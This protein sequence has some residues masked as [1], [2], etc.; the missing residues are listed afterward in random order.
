MN[1]GITLQAYTRRITALLA[2]DPGIKGVWVIAE[3]S[4]V[5]RH[6]SGHCYMEL[7]QK[8][9]MTGQT[10]AKM[11]ATL[12]KWKCIELDRK[13]Y[14]GTGQRF[15]SGMKVLLRLE[16]NHTDLYGLTANI[17][18]IDPAYTMGEMERIRR[19]I[20]EKLA[21]KGII[22]KNKQ[23]RMSLNPQMIA[24]ISAAGAAGYGDFV[25]QINSSPEGYVFYPKLF[26]AVM[27]GTS[28]A[29]SVIEALRCIEATI[30][31][32]DCV[33]IIRGGGATTDLNGFDNYELAEEI[34]NYSLPVIV[35]IGHERDR[36]V[37]DDIAAVRCKTPTAVAAFLID[38]MRRAE[39]IADDI[40]TDILSVIRQKLAFQQ[41]RLARAKALI[42]EIPIKR[43]QAESRNLT[44][45]GEYIMS[46]AKGRTES[47]R[48]KL[49]LLP[50][51]LRS[52]IN[53]ALKTQDLKIDHYKELTNILSPSNTLQRGYSITR[54]NGKAIRSAAG[55][56]EGA[57]LVTTLFD[58]SLISKKI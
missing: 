42:P 29:T 46:T 8:D 57:E 43:I 27:Q 55:I 50:E 24:V 40:A 38:S 33:V 48:Q 13:F 4:D 18:D 51:M 21:K 30:D 34:A 6:P 26:P 9:E 28:T 41:E 15:N 39:K 31:L 49:N 23:Q 19:E 32:W 20:L 37:L 45:L 3:L 25:N 5:N 54:V 11:R 7:I 35:G 17:I 2:S 58:G 16:A 1:Q 12:W 53:S 10:I 44:R 36:T 56:P 22:D 52:A 14:Q 47:A